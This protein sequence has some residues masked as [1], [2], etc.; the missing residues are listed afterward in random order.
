MSTDLTREMMRWVTAGIQEDLTRDLFLE[1][2][3]TCA[4]SPPDESLTADGLLDTINLFRAQCAPRLKNPL[5]PVMGLRM[6]ESLHCTVSKARW[7][8]VRRSWRER[9]FSRPRRWRAT[10]RPRKVYKQVPDP[11]YY[12]LNGALVAH[13]VTMM[14]LKV[15]MARMEQEKAPRPTM[16]RVEYRRA[17]GVGSRAKGEMNGQARV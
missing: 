17:F 1:N 3:T 13:P 16:T 15:E 12:M 9:L 8:R 6:I 2:A 10:H 11:S 4:P 14:A 5:G 7:T